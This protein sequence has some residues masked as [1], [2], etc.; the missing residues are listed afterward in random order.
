M[1]KTKIDLLIYFWNSAHNF[2]GK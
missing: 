1:I 2:K